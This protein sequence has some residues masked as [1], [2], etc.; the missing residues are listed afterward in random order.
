M[1]SLTKTQKYILGTFKG[2]N[3]TLTQMQNDSLVSSNCPV[4]IF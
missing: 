3:I 2:A 1:I 4:A